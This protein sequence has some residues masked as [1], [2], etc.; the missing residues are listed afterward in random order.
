M[1]VHPSSLCLRSM[2]KGKVASPY[3]GL[4]PHMEMSL[5]PTA[6]QDWDI[7]S[8]SLQPQKNGKNLGR[9]Y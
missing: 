6:L 9:Q 3:G 4:N 1:L 8:D 5:R 7:Q 2:G